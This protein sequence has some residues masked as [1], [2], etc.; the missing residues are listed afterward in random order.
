MVDMVPEIAF[1]QGCR[2]RISGLDVIITMVHYYEHNIKLY[3]Y[4]L[5]MPQDRL[6]MLVFDR[7]GFSPLSLAFLQF[8]SH[9]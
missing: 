1:S 8:K 4:P 7:L 6:K 2:E 3:G 5:L 9:T